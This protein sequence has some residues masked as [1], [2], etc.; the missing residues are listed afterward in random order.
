MLKKHQDL[1]PL[2][3]SLFWAITKGSFF[4][5]LIILPL[6]FF[7]S[8]FVPWLITVVLILGAI[9]LFEGAEK[10]TSILFLTNKRLL[11]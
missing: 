6:L 3:K 8:Y 10:Y 4:N 1:F 7:L 9:Y 2:E 11:Q 5:K